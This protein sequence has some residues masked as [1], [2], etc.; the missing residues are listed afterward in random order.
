MLYLV[1][2]QKYI[3]KNKEQLWQEDH[4]TFYWWIGA[5]FISLLIIITILITMLS[6]FIMDKKIIFEKQVEWT[7]QSSTATLE[8]IR[9]AVEKSLNI[10]LV[11]QVLFIVVFMCA[12]GLLI[13]S[14]WKSLKSKTFSTLSVLPT[15]IV[16]FLG[17]SSFFNFISLIGQSISELLALS[18]YYILNF[19]VI[20]IVY[21]LVWFLVSRNV[22]IIRRLFIRLENIEKFE[23]VIGKKIYEEQLDSSQ[24]NPNPSTTTK[25]TADSKKEDDPI[26]QRLNSLE[27]KGL[28][29]I[30]RELSISGYDNMDK[31]E[32]LNIIYSIYKNLQK[33]EKNEEIEIET[34][35]N[36]ETKDDE[37]K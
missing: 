22:A 19:I 7:Q 17:F 23:S 29:Q 14:F 10:E 25:T 21:L 1:N 13:H 30:A 37:I 9:K 35:N 6:I 24:S 28:H 20:K 12:L 15:G 31:T 34:I 16:F 27:E 11:V 2:P 5:L 36:K 4:K 3:K 18:N 32:L 33:P 26:Y 8:E